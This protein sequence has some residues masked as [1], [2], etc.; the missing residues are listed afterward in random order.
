[1][2]LIRKL[3]EK[4]LFSFAVGAAGGQARIRGEKCCVWTASSDAKLLSSAAT[5]MK[6]YHV[7]FSF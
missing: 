1:M 4:D 5:R 6:M 2:P 3:A 7:F